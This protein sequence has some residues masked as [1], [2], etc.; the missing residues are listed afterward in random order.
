MSRFYSRWKKPLIR[1]KILSG[2]TKYP[3]YLK[4][5]FTYRKMEG[6]EFIKLSDTYP[7]LFDKTSTTGV[8]SHYFY[9][10]L[11]AF[12][13]ILQ[14]NP[15]RHID[16]GSNVVF[17][18]FLTGITHVSFVDI[19]PLKVSNVSNLESIKGSILEMPFEDNSVDSLSCL[20][21]AEHIGLGRYGDPLDPLGTKKAAAELSRCLAKGGNLFFS[22]PVGKPR[23][24]FN[25]HRIHSPRQILDYFG[26]LKLIELSGS[27]DNKNFIENIDI[28][29]LENSRYACGM[30]WFTKE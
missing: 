6:A 22:L 20:H 17:V 1:T 28:E 16:V 18:G 15:I 19:R 10:D 23:L 24:C 3:G 26:G 21:V 12:K 2:L 4:D 9:Q 27:D 7:C 25:A 14:H 29:I 11:W 13:K 8:D 30:L 5:L